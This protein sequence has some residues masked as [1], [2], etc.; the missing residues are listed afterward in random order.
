MIKE[1]TDFRIPGIVATQKGTLLRYCECRRTQSDWADIDILVERS[2]DCGTTWEKVHL[3]KSNG[4]TLNNPVMFVDGERV[5]FLY[6]K[7]YAEIHRRI[8][9]DDGKS[10]GEDKI[11]NFKHDISYTVI[12][13]G[14]GHGIKHKGRLIIPVW[15]AYNREYATAHAP[16]FISTFYSEDGGESWKIGEVIFKSRLTNPSE[17]ALAVTKENNVLISIRH[18]G[19]PRKR[20]L[21]QSRD[22]ISDWGDLH[23]NENLSDPVCM[24]SM[25]SCDGIVYH[26]NCDS[27]EKRE[28]LTIKVSGDGFKTLYSIQV[29]EK[30]GYSDLVIVGDKICVFYEIQNDDGN[31]ELLFKA[32][33]TDVDGGIACI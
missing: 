8:I 12:A 20:A 29:S 3:E 15:F 22:G 19:M 26:S 28:M 27:T 4:V 32:I 2:T 11:V 14:P 10:F 24:G 31:F 5:I 30:G 9:T 18:E 7:N 6:C 33:P 23:F 25:T 17:C 21:A 16:S 13:L 1:Y